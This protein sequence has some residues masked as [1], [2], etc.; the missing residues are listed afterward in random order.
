MLCSALS[1]PIKCR[2]KSQQGHRCCKPAVSLTSVP[3]QLTL[4]PVQVLLAH[5]GREECTNP[6]TCE[7]D[8]NPEKGEWYGEFFPEIPKIK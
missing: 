2:D 7:K 1:L 8:F 5:A 4:H 6:D 3:A